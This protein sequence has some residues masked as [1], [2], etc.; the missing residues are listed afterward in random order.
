MP[1]LQRSNTAIED[2]PFKVEHM[3]NLLHLLKEEIVN[4][5]E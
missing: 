4:G 3:A 5:P 2:C 1:L